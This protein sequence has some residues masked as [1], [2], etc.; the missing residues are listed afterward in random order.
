M[1]DLRTLVRDQMER[2]GSPSYS[3]DDLGRRRDRKRRNRRIRAGLVG[4]AVFLAAMWFVRDL[5]SLDSTRSVVPGGSG[6]TGPA[7]NGPADTGR[8]VDCVPG[9]PFVP[10]P[11]PRVSEILPPRRSVPATDYLFDLDTGQ[12]T[13]LPKSIVGD[14][15][16]QDYAPSPDGSK[17]AYVGPGDNGS[18]QVFIAN[19][20][21]TGVG[22]VTEDFV[23]GAPAWSPDGSKIAYIGE[24][25]DDPANIFVLDLVTGASVQVTFEPQGVFEDPWGF[26]FSFTPDGDSIVY[27]ATIMEADTAGGEIRIVP[28]AG[29]ESAPLVNLF[30]YEGDLQLSPDGSHLA[31]SCGTA[32]SGGICVAVA[33][34][35]THGGR[36]VAWGNGDSIGGARWSPDG[37]RV[38]FSN[39]HQMNVFVLH[40]DT[41]AMQLVT[42]GR[43]PVWLDDDTL[44]VDPD[45]IL[46]PR[47]AHGCDG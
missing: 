8:P 18:S 33:D 29:G 45:C 25:G 34:G 37:T 38:V 30:D 26:P 47:F 15:W 41:G 11:C 14:D 7:E 36:Q 28:I 35:G 3:F 27:N 4:I 39:F 12:M 17:L 46:G 40:V 13:P 23:T 5:T 42:Y 22:Q 9:R 31:Y 20:D 16:N 32:L 44:I 10:S 2:A 1:A 24:R 19:L 6:T 21:G 43:S